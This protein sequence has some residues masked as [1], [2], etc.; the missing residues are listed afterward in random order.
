MLLE[1]HFKRNLRRLPMILEAENTESSEYYIINNEQDDFFSLCNVFDERFDY[2]WYDGD[3][4]AEAELLDKDVNQHLED[5]TYSTDLYQ[6]V[7]SFLWKNRHGEYEGF[8]YINP[9]RY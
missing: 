7:L 1:D 4:N 2:G 3:Q 6:K 8:N 5:G 9:Q